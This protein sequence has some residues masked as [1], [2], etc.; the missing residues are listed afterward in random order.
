MSRL[1]PIALVLAG[2]PLPA[3]A[4]AKQDIEEAN[5][6][7]D[8]VQEEN[9]SAL[10][11]K[12]LSRGDASPAQRA[13]MGILLAIARFNLRDVKG[14]RTAF[15]SALDADPTVRPPKS[16]PPKGWSIFEEVRVERDKDLAKAAEPPKVAPGSGPIKVG[17]PAPTPRM[18]GRKI[19]GIGVTAGGVAAAVA[20]AVALQNA[21]GLRNRA[22]AEPDA[23]TS[24]ALFK[25]GASS[26]TA[27]GVLLGI[28]AAAAAAGATLFLW[29][30]GGHPA[31]VSVGPAGVSMAATF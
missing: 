1:L 9:A 11:S 21:A 5:R 10:L 18:S 17:Q 13:E 31:A 15:R 23:M 30:E 7:L 24:A 14:T 22:V 20:G 16:L 25:S 6:L 27:G 12:A 4:G 8:A 28:G 26:N 29:P 3:A 2:L 19:A